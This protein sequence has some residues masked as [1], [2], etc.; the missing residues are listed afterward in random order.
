MPNDTLSTELRT[1]ADLKKIDP[2]AWWR[3]YLEFTPHH[4][5]PCT[6]CK[7]FKL[8]PCSACALLPRPALHCG[9]CHGDGMELCG[10]CDG[11]GTEIVFDDEWQKG[12]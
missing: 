8:L 5:T 3:R 9:L 12:E 7:G 1:F 2:A 6:S 10:D 11:R 4:L